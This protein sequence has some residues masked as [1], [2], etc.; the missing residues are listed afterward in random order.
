[1]TAVCLLFLVRSSVSVG[2]GGECTEAVDCVHSGLVCNGS[3]DEPGVCTYCTANWECAEHGS[4]ICGEPEENGSGD[5]EENE[6]GIDGE[7]GARKCAR[8]AL[9]RVFGAS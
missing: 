3:E 9:Q 2:L 8:V 6:P 7:R 5:F 4:F 1:M